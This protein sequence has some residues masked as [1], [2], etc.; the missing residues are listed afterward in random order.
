MRMKLQLL[1]EMAPVVKKSKANEE[2]NYFMIVIEP[3]KKDDDLDEDDW[4]G[5]VKKLSSKTRKLVN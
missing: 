4:Q 3:I 1:S 2:Q 5:S